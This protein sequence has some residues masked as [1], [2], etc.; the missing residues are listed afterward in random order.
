MHLARELGAEV[1]AV[2]LWVRASTGWKDWLR[3][4]RAAASDPDAD[5]V[6]EMLEADAGELLTFALVA[7]HRR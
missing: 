4:A 2:D 6:V 1:C 3:W 7:A 5:A